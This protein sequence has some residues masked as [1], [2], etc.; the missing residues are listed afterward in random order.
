MSNANINSVYKLRQFNTLFAKLVIALLETTIV[1]VTLKH[2]DVVNLH[3][4]CLF[5][6]SPFFYSIPIPLG[7]LFQRDRLGPVRTHPW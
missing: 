3:T 5:V 1:K 7:E 4:F 6:Q 2:N